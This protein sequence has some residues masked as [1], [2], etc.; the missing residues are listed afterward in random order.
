MKISSV[1]HPWN[2]TP[3]EAIAIQNRLRTFLSLRWENPSITCVAGIDCSYA[4]R[5]GEGYAVVAVMS[6]PGLEEMEMASAKGTVS[7]PYIPGLLTFREAPLV[8][9]AWERL[10]RRPD[11]IFVDGQGIAHPRSMGLAAHLGLLLAIPAIGC[12]KTSLV[13]GDPLTKGSPPAVGSSRGDSAPLFH[14]GQLVGAALR[15]RTGIKP[16]YVSPGHRIDIDAACHM[17]LK[18]CRGFRLPEPVRQAHAR[19]N[20]LR[21]SIVGTMET[22]DRGGEVNFLLDSSSR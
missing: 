10:R 6:W 8:L 2:V 12:A 14:K 18:A 1:D 19:A 21:A 11:L 16:V 13:G 15:T 3:R 22:R 4:K 9:E 17:V 20:Q 5:G 7:F